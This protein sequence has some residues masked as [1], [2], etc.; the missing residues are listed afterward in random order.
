LEQRHARERRMVTHPRL[1]SPGVPCTATEVGMRERH[2]LAR[3]GVIAGAI[4]ATGVALWF[5]IVD[6]FA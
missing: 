6:T 1:T 2:N 4:G 5:L 3:E